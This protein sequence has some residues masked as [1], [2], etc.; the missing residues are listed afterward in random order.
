MLLRVI[1]RFSQSVGFIMLVTN[2]LSAWWHHLL[3][4]HCEQ[5]KDEAEDSKV[6]P[7]CEVLRIQL[8]A[9]NAEKRMLLDS[10]LRVKDVSSSSQTPA[11]PQV[12]RGRHTSFAV[13]RQMLEAED[14]VKA[15]LFKKKETEI[16]LVDNKEIPK[17]PSITTTLSVGQTV[18]AL[19]KELGVSNG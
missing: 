1:L 4:P 2:S 13:K 18:E 6:C 8:E 7:T 19:E 10:I 15:E 12:I 11:E 14:R 16:K 17:D 5:C 3:N 9:A